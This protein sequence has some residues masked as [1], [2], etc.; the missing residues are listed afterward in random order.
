MFRK[1]VGHLVLAL[2]L[3]GGAAFAS[4]QEPVP[5]KE[6][7]PL[8]AKEAEIVRVS[9]EEAFQD[10]PV[11]TDEES[12]D[13]L[14]TDVPI[15]F[16]GKVYSAEELGREGIHLSHIALDNY[17]AESR[18]A[19]G[20][21]TGEDLKRYLEQTGQMPSNEPVDGAAAMRCFPYSSFFFE[22]AYYGGNW[23]A[24]APGYGHAN[25]G[26]YWNDRISSVWASGCARWT[27]LTEHPNFGG[28]H[29]WV[30]RG[31]ALNNLSNYGWWTWHWWRGFR[32]NSWNDRASSVAVFW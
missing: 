23:F 26:W 14:L 32:W 4:G 1:V 28:H 9:V 8:P 3:V 15:L 13:E 6:L 18:L 10:A 21:R 27:L 24:V 31:W 7:E 17:S 29:L 19:L 25:L 5:P 2:S 11:E 22:H 30:A 12:K 20:F 16:E